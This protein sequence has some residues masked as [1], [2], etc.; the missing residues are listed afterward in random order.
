MG[1]RRSTEDWDKLVAEYYSIK[2]R[3][4]IKEYCKA[5]KI[6]MNQFHENKRKLK[7]LL[8]T[9][10]SSFFGF[11]YTI[12]LCGF[13][14]IKALTHMLNLYVYINIFFKKIK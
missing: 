12:D 11:Y 5:K 10:L 4:T 3:I 6:C 2:P 8:K 14:D 13:K 9:P 1:K 7:K